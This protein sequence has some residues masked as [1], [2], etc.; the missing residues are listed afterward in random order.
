MEFIYIK[1]NINIAVIGKIMKN[2]VKVYLNLKKKVDMK[3]IL[4]MVN[5]MVLVLS[6]IKMVMFIK[7]NGKMVKK[8]VKVYIHLLKIMKD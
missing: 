4:R 2:M 6:F 3:V 8:M 5:V 1:I 7:V